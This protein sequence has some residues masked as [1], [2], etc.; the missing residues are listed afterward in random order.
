MQLQDYAPYTEADI[1]TEDLSCALTLRMV[2]TGGTEITYRFYPYSTRRALY[3]INGSGEFYVL[4][5]V[6]QKVI[7]D[8]TR[9]IEGRTVD[10]EAKS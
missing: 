1:E 5:K 10:P 7:D 8:C 9:V 6:M 2:T 3:T 4:R